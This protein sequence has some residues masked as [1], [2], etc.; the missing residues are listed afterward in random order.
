MGESFL[1]EPLLVSHTVAMDDDL[2]NA[3]IARAGWVIARGI[4]FFSG[5]RGWVA[6]R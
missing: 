2:I 4:R 1:E 5:E 3:K 6:W